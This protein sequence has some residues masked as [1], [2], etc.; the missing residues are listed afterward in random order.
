MDP[1]LNLLNSTPINIQ[2]L[3]E[4][5]NKN[6]IKNYICNLL[7]QVEINHSPSSLIKGNF[8]LFLS[9]KELN[10][11]SMVSKI[12]YKLVHFTKNQNEINKF[13]KKVSSVYSTDEEVQAKALKLFKQKSSSLQA[14]EILNIIFNNARMN[15]IPE[16]FNIFLNSHP[17]M[18]TL[19][20]VQICKSIL[21][22]EEHLLNNALLTDMLKQHA[23]VPPNNLSIYYDL[24]YRSNHPYIF[25]LSKKPLLEKEYTINFLWV[26]L[27]PQD[28]SADN[29]QNIFG[30]GINYFE[31]EEYLKDPLELQEYEKKEFKKTFTY[32]IS[33]WAELNPDTQIN[34]WYDSALVTQVG[35]KNTFEMMKHISELRRVKLK[36]KDVRQLTHIN[37]ELVKYLHP[38]TNVYFRVDLL[39]V[40]IADHMM[41]NVENHTKYTII[42][43]IDV[44]P[45]RSYELFDQRTLDY[46]SSKG[47]VFNKV[48]IG[49]FENSFF[50]FKNKNEIL[51]KTH[52][53]YILEEVIKKITYLSGYPPD[54]NFYSEYALDAQ[55]VFR[56]YSN[57]LRK[58]GEKDS[59]SDLNL[60]RKI[61][62]CPRS[63]FNFGG[64]FSYSD[65]KAEIFHFWGDDNIPYTKNGRNYYEKTKN[66]NT[67]N[68]SDEDEDDDRIVSNEIRKIKE[69]LDWKAEPLSSDFSD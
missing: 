47:Y 48:G 10:N 57:F 18:A 33:K 7:N 14:I 22:D 40:L 1:N 5:G 60:P 12:F 19:P 24:A 43:D 55:L 63:Q 28:R 45:M 58:M 9:K 35:Q 4:I 64:N 26:N 6:N 53:K 67:N 23:L 51:R 41:Q 13:K 69:L 42:S 8:A 52:Y 56:H 49:N 44:E 66:E 61:V 20:H 11:L 30:N 50:I 27:N 38:G 3:K 31:N 21:D 34:L 62:R 39:K 37:G 46:L 29:A 2:E 68:E 25:R 17:S 32:R 65:Y 15:S 36:L 54:R 59:D 16:L